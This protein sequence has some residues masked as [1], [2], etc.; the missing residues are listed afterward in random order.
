[1]VANVLKR[2]TTTMD[3]NFR[4]Y[5]NNYQELVEI[6]NQVKQERAELAYN[7]SLIESFANPIIM[8]V[9]KM[10]S[11]TRIIGPAD[12]ITLEHSMSKVAVTLD[13]KTGKLVFNPLPIKG[14]K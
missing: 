2:Y 11:G 1:M 10:E 5:K 7:A 13:P 3:E 4:L 14:D 6:E 9:G 12:S 8:V